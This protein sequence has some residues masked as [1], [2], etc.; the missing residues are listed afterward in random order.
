[1]STEVNTIELY[2]EWWLREMLTAGYIKKYMRE[3]ETLV[4]GSPITYG[5]IKRFKRKEKQIEEFNLF[6]EVKYTY[7]YVIIWNE[8][9]EYIFYEELLAEP[10]F[11]FGKPLFVAS[12]AIIAHSD[13]QETEEEIVS[14]VDVKPTTNVMQKG[15]KVSSAVSFPFKQRLCYTTL[16]IYINKVVPIPMAGSGYKSALFIKSFTPQRYLLTDGATKRRKIKF[17]ITNLNGYVKKKSDYIQN[18]LENTI[19]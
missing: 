1:M 13:T 11:Q 15:G 16:G 7:D 10:V 9:A 4:A 18:L 3:P 12:R 8:A 5:R 19:N 14:Y 17:P 6:P 2:F